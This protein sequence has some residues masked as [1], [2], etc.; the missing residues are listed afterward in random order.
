MLSTERESFEAELQV[1]L[2]AFDTPLTDARKDAYWRALER[3][4]LLVLKRTVDELIGDQGDAKLPTPPR[5][6]AASR[7]LRA[8]AP[9][10]NPKDDRASKF[11]DFH[12][13]GQRC[14]LWFF[15]THGA[16][17]DAALPKLV[18][19]T[20]RI[21]NGVRTSY[22]GDS[23]ACDDAGET[24]EFRDMLLDAFA[25]VFE[26][27]TWEETE[28]DREKFC[29]E[30][31]MPFTPRVRPATP[32][33]SAKSSPSELV[34]IGEAFANTPPPGTPEVSP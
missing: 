9:D 4:P 12:R 15:A 26:P 22:G 31:N 8:K 33:S 18:A 29:A 25:K 32:T 1:L 30:R 3:M 19:I 23:K 34:P 14:L 2:S 24:A 6:W 28:R 20:E 7:E 17:T 10:Q 13:L 16:P 5:I 27:R 11:D 21:V